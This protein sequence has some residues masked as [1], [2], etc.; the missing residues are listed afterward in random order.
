MLITPPSHFF[1]RHTSIHPKTQCQKLQSMKSVVEQ[2]HRVDAGQPWID[3][4]Y[5]KVTIPK[6][7]SG[8]DA[9]ALLDHSH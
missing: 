7:A 1:E 3:I 5:D 2:Y 6:P 4:R 8:Q 9:A